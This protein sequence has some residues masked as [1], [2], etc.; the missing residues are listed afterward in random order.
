MCSLPPSSFPY[1]FHPHSAHVGR[2]VSNGSRHPWP[3]MHH[4]NEHCQHLHSSPKFLP[5]V[6][7]L[8]KALKVLW[9]FINP[10]W[11]GGT[12]SQF[13]AISLFNQLGSGNRAMKWFLIKYLGKYEPIPWKRCFSKNWAA[14]KWFFLE[15]GDA[16][17]W[18]MAWRVDCLTKWGERKE[19][20]K[21][22]KKEGR[23]KGRGSSCCHVC[24]YTITYRM[25]TDG[26]L[27]NHM[28]FCPN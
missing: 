7:L 27:L 12:S 16:V 19:G 28:T 4:I 5:L 11:K 8:V 9:K 17:Q 1:F 3:L 23:N 20:R 25:G 2:S 21:E 22:Q 13:L 15:I 10:L 14:L 6:I 18:K 26:V 24:P